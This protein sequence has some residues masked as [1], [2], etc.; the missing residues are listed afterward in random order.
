LGTTDVYMANLGI[1]ASAGRDL[2][3]AGGDEV[4]GIID[5]DLNR[6]D[7]PTPLDV[8][9]CIDRSGSMSGN[10]IEV[11][12]EGLIEAAKALGPDDVFGVVSFGSSASQEVEPTEGSA[13]RSKFS[14]IETI[15]IQGGTSIMSGLRKARRMLTTMS[16]PGA[17]QWIVLISDGG[18]SINQNTLNTD[19]GDCG[20]TIHAAG[21]LN[22]DQHV[23]QTVAERT[24]GEWED[25]GHPSNLGSFFKQK[26][27]EARGVVA[28]DTE[29]RLDPAQHTLIDEVFYTHGDQQSLNEPGWDELGCSLELGDLTAE[30]PPKVRL[31]L[32]IDGEAHLHDQTLL[33]VTLRTQDQSVTDSI[34]VEI[35]S[36]VVAEEE[37]DETAGERESIA[38]AEVMETALEE[39]TDQARQALSRWEGD[40]SVDDAA[41]SEAEAVIENMEQATD[42]KEARDEASRVLG[43]WDED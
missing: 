17:A 13:A 6:P 40:E 33:D 27:S 31:D 41:L 3:K 34:D 35:A 38:V 37:S 32:F 4:T 10:P 43:N 9:F 20:I 39:G 16:R 8:V 25:V 7:S 42:E 29:L 30:K 5:F 2:I 22:Y 11:A 21:I 26:I 24:Q 23:I 12:R 15:K 36:P 19:Y 18:S 1:S 28:L 14:D